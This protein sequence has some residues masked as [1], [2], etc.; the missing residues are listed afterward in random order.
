MSESGP[1]VPVGGIAIHLAIRK[2]N[3]EHLELFRDWMAQLDGPR[4]EEALA[5]L[6]DEGCSHELAVLIDGPDGPLWSSMRWK[7]TASRNHAKRQTTP[8]TQSTRYIDL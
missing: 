2:V 6:D 5:T 3:S 4:R 1:K 8:L 7:W